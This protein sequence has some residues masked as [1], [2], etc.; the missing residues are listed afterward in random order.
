MPGEQVTSAA[1]QAALREQL[2]SQQAEIARLQEQM[3]PLIGLPLAVAAREAERDRLAARLQARD[4]EVTDLQASLERLG[5]REAALQSELSSLRAGAIE[6]APSA[7]S[8][9]K[10]PA[11]DAP[12]PVKKKKKKKNKGNKPVDM[13]V[14]DRSTL[15]R[16]TTRDVSPGAADITGGVT[17]AVGVRNANARRSA[18]PPRQFEQAP[19]TV[20][21]LKEIKG[22][23]PVLERRLNQLGIFQFRQIADWSEEDIVYFDEHLTDFRGRIRRDDW[24]Q[25]AGQAYE[26]KYG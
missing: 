19:E 24:V 20:D 7:A 9:A 25:G 4:Q 14:A 12:A 15:R 13:P 11:E 22:I 6:T 5:E 17:R 26:R 10:P 23:G 1:S 16:G 3:A 8:Q 21:N 2:E 18:N